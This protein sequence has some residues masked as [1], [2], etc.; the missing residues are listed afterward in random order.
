MLDQITDDYYSSAGKVPPARI[1][2]KVVPDVERTN[3]ENRPCSKE[4]EWIEI[5]SDPGSIH[6]RELTD[7]DKQAYSG[8]YAR[9]QQCKVPTTV[10]G[11]ALSDLP[12]MT[13][14]RV[15]EYAAVKIFSAEQLVSAKEDQIVKAGMGAREDQAKAKAFL[16]VAQ[17]TKL[18]SKQAKTIETQGKEIE[19]LKSELE[20]LSN[21]FKE[22]KAT[23][24]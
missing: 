8:L 14:A 13:R 2:L 17:D 9:F 19:R 1:S 12:W 21:A 5:F 22:M 15:E 10:D 7:Y 4:V 16:Q 6:E 3:Q 20:T 23:K 24:S 18:V 11:T